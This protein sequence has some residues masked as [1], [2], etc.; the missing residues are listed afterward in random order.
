[1][2]FV[3]R[4]LGLLQLTLQFGNAAVTNLGRLYQVALAGGAFFVG[5]RRLK[6]GFERLD[7]FDNVLLILPLGLALRQGILRVGDFLAQMLKALTADVV[8]F[9][10]ER[11]LF[12]LHL[13]ELAFG[14]VNLFR[15]AVDF[16]TQTAGCLVHKVDG[17]IGQETV[18]DVAVREF[19]TC[20]DGGIGDA[21]AVMDFVLFLQTTQNS[22]GVFNRRLADHNRLETTFES[23]IL[24]DVLAVFVKRSG[25]DGVQFAT[26]KGG[27]EHVA[28][29]HGAVARGTCAHDGVQLVDEQDDL[30]V[31]FLDFAQH[32]LQ[33]VFEFATILRT[34]HHSAKVQGDDV[35][36][37]QA[38]RHVTCDDA[39]SQAFDDCRFANA[40]FTDK[41]GVVLR[42][43]AEHLDGAADFLGTADDRVEFTFARFLRKVLAVLVQC[44]KL[45]LALLVG[46][47]GGAAQGAVGF[48]NGFARDAQAVKHATSVAL[49]LRQ[50]DEQ[51]LSGCVAVP[52]A[53]GGLHRVVDYLNKVV[54][55]HGHWHAGARCLRHGRDCAV[56]V[57]RQLRRVGANAFDDG[58]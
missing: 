37:F 13:R 45:G 40:R 47:A 44:V 51:V 28:G 11:L 17:L 32:G 53:L 19:G 16:D 2:L 31:R 12:D 57:L 49:V 4:L 29:I 9:L 7:V 22:D 5:L 25:T 55:G 58:G 8:G 10:H 39:L 48:L 50:S 1:M 3:E 6:V 41:H 35:M 24:F 26:C 15:H 14:Q 30:P 42:A 18:G 21:H 33:A 46:N 34:C 56:D 38:G 20:H 23:G 52:H 36:V 43:A 54:A 27:L